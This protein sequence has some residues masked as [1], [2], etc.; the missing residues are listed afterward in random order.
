MRFPPI[1]MLGGG[2][3][4]RAMARF[5]RIMRTFPSCGHL[6]SIAAVALCLGACSAN[7]RTFDAR[8]PNS[9]LR[10]VR[11]IALPDVRGRVDHMT[12]DGSTNH[13]FVAEL[14]NGTVDDVDLAVGKVAGRISGLREPQGVAWLAAQQELAVACGDGLVRFFRRSD[15]REVARISLGDDADNVRLD[16]RNGHL[17]VGYGSGGL[18]VIDPATHRLL[19]RVPLDGHPEAFAIGESRVFVNVP[20]RHSLVI[21]DLD[22][23]RTVSTVPI[24]MQAGNYPM[25]LNAQGSE[26][27]VAF[28]FP[29]SASV[30]DMATSGTLLSVASCRDADDLYFIGARELAIVCGQGAVD[31]VNLEPGHPTDRVTTSP[32]ARTGLLADDGRSLFIA[33]P[34]RG[35]TAQVWQLA[36]N[37]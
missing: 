19:G 29:A 34:G 9:P 11:T 12:I 31:L 4:K 20:G 27:A 26:L 18:A 13:L 36:V 3:N 17:I 30:I 16:S 8:D 6:G 37:R 25:A 35:S 28:R 21:A 22:L 33:V 32:G 2:L 1:A 15:W 7:A 23:G 14:G 24:G 5:Q 10:L